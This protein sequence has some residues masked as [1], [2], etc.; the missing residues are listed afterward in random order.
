MTPQE[1]LDQGRRFYREKRY[2][3]AVPLLRSVLEAGGGVEEVWQELVIAAGWSDQHPLAVEFGKEAL[4]H[5]PRSAWLWRQV[6][7]EL[8]KCERL[9]EAEKA[10][11]NASRLE[12]DSEWVWRY[13]VEL[14]KKRK[15]AAKQIEALERLCALGLAKS[16]DLNALGIVCH[17][18]RDFGRALHWYRRSFL[19]ET[20]KAPLFNM[21]LVFGDPEVSQDAD[22]A[23][24]YRRA[25]AIDPTYKVAQ[26]RLA[27]TRQKLMPLAARATAGGAAL[28][29]PREYYQFYL[30]P[31]EA[32]AI[33]DIE[34]PEE[35]DAKTI[36][37][38]KKRLLSEIELND[39]KV[40]WLGDYAVDRSRA[41]ALEN[42]LLDEEKRVFHWE[43]FENKPLLRF[44]TRGEIAHF[45]YSDAYFPERTLKLLDEEPA[46]RAFLSEPFA[47]QYS[48]VLGRAIERR[49]LPVIEVL[50]DGRRWVLPEHD[51][52]CFESANRRV[53]EL[54]ELVSE[55]KRRGEARKVTLPEISETLS[56]DAVAEVFNL[57]PA[58][59]RTQQA[60]VVGEIRS[61][62]VSC[63]NEHNDSDLSRAILSLCKKFQFKSAELTKRVDEDFKTIERLIAEERKHETRLQFGK[64]RSFEITKDGIRDGGTFET[65][66]DI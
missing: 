60:A 62:A 41:L 22:A 39:G 40:G 35:L 54:L 17:N 32:F 33:D 55:K 29:E 1:Q 53:A 57:L 5:Y 58:P 34:E 26:E 30:S 52:V 38:A 28:V 56:K 27:V 31:F 51:D 4:R 15:N 2:A 36:Q 45:V 46:F 18:E 20:D 42:E 43:V 6:G 9:D 37:R 49:W 8:T 61:L 19:E 59:F 16:T 3:E 12:P 44:L 63:Y 14:Q 48:V 25:L 24:A 66:R 21:G 50:F 65:D 64:E 23:D 47:R 10:L 7:S 13:F 11:A